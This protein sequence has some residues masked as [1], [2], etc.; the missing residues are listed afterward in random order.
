MEEKVKLVQQWDSRSGANGVIYS[1][2]KPING[3]LCATEIQFNLRNSIEYRSVHYQ[4]YGLNVQIICDPNLRI[5]YTYVVGPRKMNNATIYRRL[6]DLHSWMNNLE[7][8]Y[9]CSG[10]NTFL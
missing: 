5:V 8:G 10:D 4:R 7:D 3:W 9:F 2:L 1:Y 6:L